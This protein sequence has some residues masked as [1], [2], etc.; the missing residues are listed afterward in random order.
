[1]RWNSPTERQ[2]LPEKAFHEKR[3]IHGDFDENEKDWGSPNNDLIREAG[4][5]TG[6]S[7][8]I[9]RDK[10]APPWGLLN[11]FVKRPEDLSEKMREQI[12]GLADR[13]GVAFTRFE[14]HRI[15]VQKKVIFDEAPDGILLVDPDSLVLLE[16]NKIFLDMLGASAQ[17][18]ATG[19]PIKEFLV[20]SEMDFNLLSGLLQGYSGHAFLFRSRIKRADGTI[21]TASTS[22]SLIPYRDKKALHHPY[23]GHH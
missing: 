17:K 5:K 7:V 21:F 8:P 10:N 12:K 15:E 3:P 6:F 14:E 9:P 16:S 1:S 19:K 4:I 11:I 20:S 22:V 18:N 13:V 23:Q 2:I